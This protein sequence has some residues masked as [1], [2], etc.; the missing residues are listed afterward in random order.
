MSSRFSGILSNSFVSI[1]P[2]TVPLRVVWPASEGGAERTAGL[3]ALVALEARHAV[4]GGGAGRAASV[5]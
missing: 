4:K 5:P 3:R 2:K 1:S